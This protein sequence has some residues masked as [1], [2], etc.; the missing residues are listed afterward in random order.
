MRT[1]C[2]FRLQD[3]LDLVLK[4]PLRSRPFTARS[5][6]SCTM[7]WTLLLTLVP[8]VLASDGQQAKW[9]RRGIPPTLEPM[10]AEAGTSKEMFHQYSSGTGIHATGSDATGRLGGHAPQTGIVHANHVDV[11]SSETTLHGLAD[12]DWSL[13]RSMFGSPAHDR[14]GNNLS[15][16]S[17]PTHFNEDHFVNSLLRT[18]SRPSTPSHH[19]DAL[20]DSDAD[21]HQF[22]NSL[23]RT[24]SRP[25][26]PAHFRDAFHGPHL[27]TEHSIS[28]FA[29]TPLRP[30]TPAHRYGNLHSDAHIT[31]SPNSGSS[32]NDHSSISKSGPKAATSES[33]S[34][35]GSRDADPKVKGGRGRRPVEIE[36]AS[37]RTLE[38]R[39]RA[40][41][42][43]GAPADEVERLRQLTSKARASYKVPAAHEHIDPQNYQ[44]T[45]LDVL[46][47]QKWK[48]K[49]EHAPLLDNA[50]A[51]KT[52]ALGLPDIPQ[53]PEHYRVM[54]YMLKTQRGASR[55][56]SLLG[57]LP[58][59][60]RP[61]RPE[62]LPHHSAP[63]A[64]NDIAE[65]TVEPRTP[66]AE[67]ARTPSSTDSAPSSP[68]S[69]SGPFV[70]RTARAG[71][72]M[73]A[74]FAERS[75]LKRDG[76]DTAEVEAKIEALAKAKN[77]QTPSSRTTYYRLKRKAAVI[78][79]PDL[80]QMD[81][82]MSPRTAGLANS[83]FEE[84]YRGRADAESAEARDRYSRALDV[85]AQKLGRGKAPPNLKAYQSFKRRK[86]QRETAG[87]P[88]KPHDN[89]GAVKL[90]RER[91][92]AIR[93]GRDT[94]KID[95]QLVSLAKQYGLAAMPWQVRKPLLAML[96]KQDPTL[97]EAHPPKSPA[98]SIPKVLSDVAT[99]DLYKLRVVGALKGE[100][101][102]HVN[103][104]IEARLK[105]DASQSSDTSKSSDTIGGSPASSEGG[106]SK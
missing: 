27:D 97:S 21:A 77:M 25:N 90:E 71:Q 62:N 89:T 49:P 44:R 76:K 98:S 2:L 28:P 101:V 54:H 15:R 33:T 6:T 46:M 99:F 18:P 50:I 32:D 11:G 39:L 57:T 22:A 60:G 29:R 81:K 82:P 10:V 34:P 102:S 53:T 66:S 38:N 56:K 96:G 30:S 40:A 91:Y 83:T 5:S 12:H 94:S 72:N 36:V 80:E 85:K 23:L 42:L 55:S 93:A 63:A 7:R 31:E 48:V 3:S 73:S 103:A 88:L 58:R 79:D 45:R 47:R 61:P 92:A 8:I 68:A 19:N 87:L 105:R 20:Y 51:E 1:C 78:S 24:P 69:K 35:S 43:A 41:R 106:S 86:E 74:L 100:D 14:S 4:I 95:A 17:S 104:E 52:R 67:Q 84:L 59:L 64:S 75:H 16:P 65:A 37:A 70:L 13:L 26:S 9:D